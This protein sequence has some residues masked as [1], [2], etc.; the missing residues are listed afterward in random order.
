MEEQSRLLQWI[1]VDLDALTD[2]INALRDHLRAGTRFMAVVKKN[3]YGFGAVAVS[4]AA[5]EAGV[6]YL[7]VHALEE[8]LE[9][10]E[11]GI[12]APL[13]VLGPVLPGEAET[14][15]KQRLAIT[16]VDKELAHAL[17]IASQK[18]N[19]EVEVHI[20]VDTG[21]QRFGVSL[22]EAPELLN[23]LNAFP[24]LK[25][26]GLYTHFSS[27]D[28]CDETP[29]KLQLERFLKLAKLF[30]QVKLQ[31]AAN[32]AA[33]LQFPETHLDMVRVG[34]SL[35]GFYPS[36]AVRRT[37]TL[38]P[39]LEL[40]TRVARVHSIK[41]GEGV[42]YGLTWVAPE[43]SVVALIPFGYG[44]GLS[45]LLSNKGEVLIRGQRAPIR[46]V[47]CMDQSI[48]DVTEVPGV[49]VG[50]EATIIGRQGREEVTAEEIAGL[51]NTINYEVVTRLP[52]ALPRLYLHKK[53]MPSRLPK[54]N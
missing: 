3:A 15:I 1:E 22:E 21:L 10:R 16:V 12:H 46:G 41:A 47:V 30:P 39:V 9:L 2:N 35:Y 42:S 17:A 14:V 27:A 48:V 8:A 52:A 26:V 37:V 19:A 7:G 11:A 34:I 4:R 43:D 25:V 54:H 13:L 44:H 23:Y 32:S 49:S 53:T 40:K 51:T 38:K 24:A 50:D 20:K 36:D 18:L 31:H 5:L 28:E 33:T 45:R 29:T 6:D